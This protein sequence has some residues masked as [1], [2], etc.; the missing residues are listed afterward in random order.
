MKSQVKEWNGLNKTL[1][2]MGCKLLNKK[3]RRSVEDMIAESHKL[4]AAADE[5]MHVEDK[6]APLSSIS[7]MHRPRCGE[8]EDA[9]EC[10]VWDDLMLLVQHV[11]RLEKQMA[12][13]GHGYVPPPRF[14]G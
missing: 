14:G 4:I 1:K 8:G 3:M 13:H 12:S 5:A 9:C 6:L 7:R 11:V 2:D 10:P